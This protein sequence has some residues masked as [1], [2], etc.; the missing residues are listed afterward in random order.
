MKAVGLLSSGLDSALAIKLVLDQ[1]IEVTAVNIITSFANDKKDYAVH[2]AKTIGARLIEVEAGDDYIDMVRNPKHGYGRNLNPCIDCRIYML[3]HAKVIAEEIG[4]SF[5]ITGDVLGERPLSQ[6]INALHIEENESDL[7]GMIVRPL[8]ARLLPKTIPETKGWIEREQLLYI[9]GR[10]RKPQKELARKFGIDGYRTA[11][12]GCLL[13][14][15]GFSAK[16]QE[17]FNYKD[18]IIKKDIMLLRIGRHFYLPSSAI[19]VGRNKEENELLLNIRRS[20]DYVFE[21]PKHPSPV[22]IL[23]G[24]KKPEAIELAAKLTARYSDADTLEVLVEYGNDKGKYSIIV[25][26][27]LN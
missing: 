2:T 17:L 12:S 9:K 20:S 21:V 11:D 19:T 25:E 22:T 4:A 10:N 6:N 18:K 24:R 8:S 1:G 27:T 15:I 13:T 16:L 26:Q 23:R 3:R 7:K 5:I 14:D